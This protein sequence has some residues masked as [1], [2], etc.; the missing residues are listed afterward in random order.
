[1]YSLRSK[2]SDMTQTEQPEAGDVEIVQTQ[3][4]DQGASTSEATTTEDRPSIGAGDKTTAGSNVESQVGNEEETDPQETVNK[5]K[6]GKQTNQ[7]I[8]SEVRFARHAFP[9][10]GRGFACR[11]TGFLGYG[12][13]G[14]GRRGRGGRGL[15]TRGFG[16]RGMFGLGRRGRVF[17]GGRGFGGRGFGGRGFDGRPG[18]ESDIDNEETWADPRM[19]FKEWGEDAQTG[20]Q[21][22]VSS[23]EN[24]GEQCTDDEA[25]DHTGGDEEDDAPPCTCRGDMFEARGGRGRGGWG[26]GGS[27]RGFGQDPRGMTFPCRGSCQ[28]SNRPPMGFMPDPRMGGFTRP[29]MFSRRGM[30]PPFPPHGNFGGCGFGGPRLPFRPM[31]VR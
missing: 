18:E 25:D 30:R 5:R 17:Y 31:F 22:G 7:G 3:G 28:R 23:M 26:R 21:P 9:V 13:R 27:G 10:R 19:A 14:V 20:D 11:G 2:A 29:P 6:K 15:H 4:K 24:D 8:R 12:G 1:M 16:L